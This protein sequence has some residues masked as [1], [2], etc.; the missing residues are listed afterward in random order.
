MDLVIALLHARR[1]RTA[2]WIREHVA[3][4][5]DATS[6][7]SFAR[8]FERDKLELRD[9]GIPIETDQASDG[10]RIRPGDFALPPLTFTPAESAALA[11]AARLWETTVLAD[12]GGSALR[13]VRDGSAVVEPGA[14]PT[15]LWHADRLQARV[16]TAEPS[17]RDLFAAVRAHRP[18]SFDYRGLADTSAVTRHVEPWGLVNW[19]GSWYLVGFDIDRDARRTFRLSRISGPVTATGRTGTVVIPEGIDLK[20]LV[21]Q[22]ADDAGP[23][24]ALLRIREGRAA[25]LRRRGEV[26][27]R[28]G[29]DGYDDVR[30]PMDSVRDLARRVA[31]QGADVIAVDPVEL[32]T[33]VHSL[34][35]GILR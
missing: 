11:I 23:G 16:R 18:V 4:Y 13:K 6:D 30:V 22:H 12:A 25:G 17:F 31:G 1:F 28:A 29:T 19:S 9:L 7:E 3:G 14:E 15:P 26:V 20:E 21:A 5:E 24:V 35:A 34:L 32:R 27:S 2:A 33:A 8:M 10:Y